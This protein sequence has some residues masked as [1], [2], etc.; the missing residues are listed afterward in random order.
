MLYNL[1]GI[2][3]SA[4]LKST[5]LKTDVTFDVKIVNDNRLQLYREKMNENQ[6][7]KYR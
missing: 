4:H 5:L 6:R 1:S 7:M 3:K 2:K